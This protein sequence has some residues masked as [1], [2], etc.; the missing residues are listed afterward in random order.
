MAIQNRKDQCR[1]IKRQLTQ[2]LPKLTRMHHHLIWETIKTACMMGAA[3][4]RKRTLD[5]IQNGAGPPLLVQRIIE[6]SVLDVLGFG[7][8]Q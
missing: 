4:E 6:R 5:L 7:D 3:E 2:Y 1:A 8:R